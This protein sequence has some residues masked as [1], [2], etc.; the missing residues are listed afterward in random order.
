MDNNTKVVSADRRI[1]YI[2]RV[3]LNYHLLKILQANIIFGLLQ[4]QNKQQQQTV[5]VHLPVYWGTTR[6]PFIRPPELELSIYL[7]YCLGIVH[8][9]SLCTFGSPGSFFSVS[10][11]IFSGL[12]CSNLGLDVFSSLECL[13]FGDLPAS[14]LYLQKL[15][16]WN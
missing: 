6:L 12:G 8:K 7:C 14:T 2:N 3:Q 10:P 1:L 4:H 16:Y 11:M 5:T 9:V 13:I 15:Q